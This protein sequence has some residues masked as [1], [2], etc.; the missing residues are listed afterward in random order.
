[1]FYLSFISFYPFCAVF[2]LYEHVVATANPDDC[3]DDIQAL[4]N[5]G[6]VMQQACSVYSDLVPLSNTVN[7]L[8]KVVRSMQDSRGNKSSPRAPGDPMQISTVVN[9][10]AGTSSGQQ[11]QQS[12]NLSPSTAD[13]FQSILATPGFEFSGTSFP[14]LQEF[15][16]NPAGGDVQPV[17][18]IRALENDF[19]GRNWHET[20]WDMNGDI[21][22]SLGDM[23]ATPFPM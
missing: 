20:W 12:L 14:F 23:S 3:E 17:D 13:A 5:I 7:A 10:P 18:F 6:S 21:N 11:T 16:T 19:I 8:N 15:P 4:E 9:A 2:S 22:A 1:M